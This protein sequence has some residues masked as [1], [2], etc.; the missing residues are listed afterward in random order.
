LE[1]K[2]HSFVEDFHDLVDG[3]A[4]KLIVFDHESEKCSVEGTVFQKA[5]TS[6]AENLE[7]QNLQDSSF[8]FYYFWNFDAAET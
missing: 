3:F 4:V 7:F 2:G 6:Q 5:V 1:L 8:D